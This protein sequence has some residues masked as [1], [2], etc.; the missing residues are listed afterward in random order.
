MTDIA[1]Q[2][3]YIIHGIVIIPGAGNEQNADYGY[4]QKKSFHVLVINY[5]VV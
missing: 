2:R 4:G 1:Y 5:Q 3:I